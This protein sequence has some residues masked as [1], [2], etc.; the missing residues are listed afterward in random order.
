MTNQQGLFAGRFYSPADDSNRMFRIGRTGISY[1]PA[2]SGDAV[3]YSS[4]K[5]SRRGSEVSINYNISHGEI[6]YVQSDTNEYDMLWE[7]S[8]LSEKIKYRD[9]GQPFGGE[10]VLTYS[11][12]F[13]RNGRYMVLQL[14]AGVYVR[15]DMRTQQMTPFYNANRLTTVRSHT[16]SNDGRYVFTDVDNKILIHDLSSCNTSYDKNLW[17]LNQ[18]SEHYGCTSTDNLNAPINLS[19]GRNTGATKFPTFSPNSAE[20]TFVDSQSV[21]DNYRI[22]LKASDYTSSVKGYVALGDSFSSGEGDSNGDAWYEPGTDEQGST[23][24]FE[25]RNLCHLSRRS[26]PYLMAVELGYLATNAVSP[27]ADG[28]FH[29]VA[30][31]GAVTRNIAGIINSLNIRDTENQYRR[32]YGGSLGPWQPGRIKQL[33]IFEAETFAGYRQEQSPEVITLGIGGNDVDFGGIVESCTIKLPETCKYAVRGSESAARLAGTIADL[34]PTLV[35]TYTALKNT[36]PDARIYVHGYPLFIQGYNGNCGTNVALNQKETALVEEGVTYMNSVV[37][38]AAAKAGVFYVDITDILQGTNLCSHSDSSL[39]TVNGVTEGNDKGGLEKG[40]LAGLRSHVYTVCIL[41]TGCV[42]NESYHPN[43]KAHKL[44][45][46]AIMDQTANMTASMPAPVKTQIPLPD[47]F[48]GVSISEIIQ[49]ANAEDGFV[50][51]YITIQKPRSFLQYSEQPN[52]LHVLQDGLTPGSVLQV[53]GNSD[54]VLIGEYTVPENGEIDIVLTLPDSMITEPGAHE[55]HLLGVNSFGEQ[56]DYYESVQLAFSSE[57]FDG[58]GVPNEE[59]SC[60]SLQNS[61]IDEDNDLV[62]DACDSFVEPQEV[63]AAAPVGNEVDQPDTTVF[64][65]QEDSSSTQQVLVAQANKSTA[66][67]DF[68]TTPQVAAAQSSST[69]LQK[70]GSSNGLAAILYGLTIVTASCA[71]AKV[72]SRD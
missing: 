12:S 27:P 19:S 54:P 64:T 28:L 6:A 59:D 55:I 33:D 29:S 11:H 58:D 49:K 60:I 65:A 5:S 34:K 15:V 9:N 48:F 61:F 4:Y 31:S 16:I 70:T 21:A 7:P 69:D 8:S 35:K 38:S 62:D 24:T 53:W 30:C 63:A 23:S 56:I 22:T 20:L 51:N 39:K 57:D 25:G 42:G 32:D 46:R 40:W 72:A 50:S 18:S 3:L 41:S 43:E 37:K 10:R 1:Y 66:Q 14:Y 13:S 17:E 67:E 52:T 2:P 47:A 68:L 45:A 71:L 36:N 26:Y 44:Y